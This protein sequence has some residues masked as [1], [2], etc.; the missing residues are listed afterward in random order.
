LGG[1]TS[2]GSAAE[3]VIIA[4]VDGLRQPVSVEGVLLGLMIYG[5]FIA[6]LFTLTKLLPAKKVRGQPLPGTGERLTYRINGMAL[7][8]AV[9][10]LVFGGAWFLGLSLTPLLEHFWSLLVAANLITIAWLLLMNWQ[11]RAR[12]ANA[13]EAKGTDAKP[14]EPAESHG[15][16]ARLWY[17]LE[18]NPTFLGVDLKIFAYQP[19]LIGLG[20]L[21]VAFAWAQYEQL[22]HLTPQMLAY[23]MFWWAYLFTHYWIEDN[24][25]SM[26]DVIA[27]RFGF[28]LL[29]GDLVLVPF[30]Y[31]LPGWWLLANPEPMPIWQVLAIAALHVVGLW[32]F[33]ESNAQKN[34][35]KKDP[36]ATIWGKPAQTLGG[37]LL[38]SGW[39]GIGRKLN[40]SGEIMVYSS[41]S[42]CTGFASLL[43]YLL[44]LW[45]CVLLTHRAWRDE[46]RCASK[47]GELWVEY[48]KIAKFRMIPFIY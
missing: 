25:L 38:L 11:S 18:L 40:Y 7:F 46:Q 36:N 30:F 44:P 22:G 20:V 32:I 23:Q 37:R 41:F 42:L 48:T 43:P 35:F 45:L 24:V 5:S 33:R 19:S 10:M 6:V 21:N 29:W 12:L 4:L 15:P 47:Y 13:S 8:V 39:W 2:L 3:A 17:G 28:M 26:W 27:E 16:L 34:R 14:V 1:P 9:H 31:C